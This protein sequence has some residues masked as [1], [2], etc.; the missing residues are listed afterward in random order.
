MKKINNN[1]ESNNK[2]STNVFSPQN[3]MS[4]QNQCIIYFIKISSIS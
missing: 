2:Y 1:Y 4:S 3:V